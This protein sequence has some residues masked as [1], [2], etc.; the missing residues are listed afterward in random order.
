LR[1]CCCRPFFL[2]TVLGQIQEVDMDTGLLRNLFTAVIPFVMERHKESGGFGATRRLPATIQDTYHALNIL[3][4]VQRFVPVTGS[5]PALLTGDTE[6]PYL[7]AGLRLLPAPGMC[8]TF[9]LLWACRTSG[10]EFDRNGAETAVYAKME[11]SASLEE[12][13]YGAR[14]LTEILDNPH[15][16]PG[17]SITAVLSRS[18]RCIDEVWMHMYLARV[19][20]MGVPLPE[21]ELI[22]WLQACQ[23]GDGGFGFFPGTTSFIENCHACLR[24]LAVLGAKPPDPER[25]ASFLS[26]CQTAAGG[27]SR[28]GRAAPFLDATWHALASLS[29]VSSFPD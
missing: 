21:A 3:K 11:N 19:S 20:G 1:R 23:N 17:E 28:S 22:A 25:A 2:A 15:L 6:R 13:Y 12:W 18:W 5:E 24:A 29:L 7:T 4:L 8:T 14:I 9:Q 16:G 27:F 10:V 26:G